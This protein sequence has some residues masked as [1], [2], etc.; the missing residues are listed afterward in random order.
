MSL[1]S[2]V[3]LEERLQKL[4]VTKLV[5]YTAKLREIGTISKM[6][7]PVYLRDFIVAYDIT[8]TMY[9][10]AIKYDIEAQTALDQ[11][12]SIAYLDKAGDY[13]KLKGIKESSEARKQYIDLDEDVIA[14]SNMKAKTAALCA[15]L[16]NKMQEFR[17]AHDD[18][19]KMSYGE[20]YMSPEEGY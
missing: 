5:Q 15:F 2:V 14:A 17:M 10:N 13:L 12:K 6:M 11:A 7:A 9:S 8:N 3:N 19:K 4:D 1:P 18:V 16:R 20:N